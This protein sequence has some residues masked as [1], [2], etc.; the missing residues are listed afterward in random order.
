MDGPADGVLVV[1]AA[2]RVTAVR[3]RPAEPVAALAVS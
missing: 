3:A 2:D 1:R